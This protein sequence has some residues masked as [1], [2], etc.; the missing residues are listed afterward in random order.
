MRILLT[1]L[2]IGTL[3][4]NATNYYFSA[5][6]S[7]GNNGT[8]PA[9]AWQTNTKFN[10]TTFTNGDSIFFNRGDSWL[11]QFKLK[12][13]SLTDRIYVGNYGSGS[14]PLFTGF[15]AVT[16]WTSAGTNKWKATASD[17][18]TGALNQ[19]TI[20]NTVLINGYIGIKARNP[21]NSYSSYDYTQ[22]NDSVL[23]SGSATNRVGD[24]VAIKPA[25]WIWD[26]C[27]ITSQNSIY[28]SLSPKMTYSP[29]QPDVN[30]YFL[31]NDV[32]FLDQPNEWVFS[33]TTKTLYVYSTTSPTNV[34]VS[35]I[36]TGF[37]LS[38]N[39][40]VTIDGIDFT[41]FNKV[42]IQ[43]DTARS[44]IIKNC[45]IKNCGN[46]GIKKAKTSHSKCDHD[47]LTNCLSTGLYGL[48]T[49]PYTPMIDTCKFDTTINCVIDS[50]AMFAG[51]GQSGNDTYCAYWV[52]GDSDVMMNNYITNTGY[53]AIVPNGRSVYIYQNYVNGTSLIKDD[54][55]GIHTG[56]G[57]YIP[58]NN[59]S[60]MI[61]RKN[62]VLNGG[63]ATSTTYNSGVYL[64]DSVNYVTVDSNI[65][66]NAS[67]AAMVV[68]V[69]HDIVNRYNILDDSIGNC[70]Q[71]FGV[72][73]WSYNLTIT[74]NIFAQR[75]GYYQTFADANSNITILDSNYYFRIKKDSSISYH[76]KYYKLLPDFM[77][78]THFETHSKEEPLPNTGVNP[79]LFYN[80]KLV[81]STIVLT[82]NMI[83]INGGL[84]IVNSCIVLH[85]FTGIELFNT[86]IPIESSKLISTY[87]P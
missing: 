67:H 85:P 35:I 16:G 61:I 9:T 15:E 78:A 26:V 19:P 23:A 77:N 48:S 70:L 46:Y 1:I 10:N 37:W 59:D 44:I 5:S 52:Y 73:I 30:Q 80:N 74:H 83:D 40:N 53:V 50:T 42:A 6:G 79:V 72:A 71:D 84:H 45:T 24:E 8:S 4:A 86:T 87:L 29:F 55:G 39:Q 58:L 12:T 82:A 13:N 28:Y 7:D 62:I 63:T 20:L 51:M 38:Q 22:S 81:D 64:D 3:T 27:K 47:T 11:G 65:V 69:G 49:N 57:D 33:D 36:D 54:G 66:A 56:K 31:C 32:A 68:G 25:H 2:F 21:N 14:K 60:L 17:V 41:G 34:K 43:V 75:S 18:K 76:G